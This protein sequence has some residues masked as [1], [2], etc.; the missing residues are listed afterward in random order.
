MSSASTTEPTWQR[1]M[2][3]RCQER[4]GQD[5]CRVMTLAE[6]VT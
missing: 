3:S 1:R 6:E 2:L 4:A 5:V